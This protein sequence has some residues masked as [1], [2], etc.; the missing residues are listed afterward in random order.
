MVSS[1]WLSA[2]VKHLLWFYAVDW[3][4]LSCVIA[5]TVLEAMFSRQCTNRLFGSEP[6]FKGKNIVVLG[7]GPSLVKG[8]PLGKLIDGMD[9]VV[10]F[11]NFQTKSQAYRNGPAQRP[12]CISRTACYIPATQSTKCQ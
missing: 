1:S 9:E 2:F 3:P 10:R 4:M 8:D 6:I 5:A 11:N 12:P 7:N